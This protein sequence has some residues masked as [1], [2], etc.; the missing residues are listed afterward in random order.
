M[1]FLAVPTK[2]SMRRRSF[3]MPNGDGALDTDAMSMIETTK[4][5]IAPALPNTLRLGAVH[6]TVA[7]VDRAVA[8]YE[9]S[10]GLRVHV[11]GTAAATG[12][13][14]SAAIA[15]RRRRAS[16]SNAR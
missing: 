6:L 8:W 9:R 4:P 2:K 15:P 5:A 10:L 13:S 1:H 16:Q 14:A 3:P 12:A 7:D 11:H